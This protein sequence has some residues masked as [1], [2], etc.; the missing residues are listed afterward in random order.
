MLKILGFVERNGR[1]TH[2]EYR[3]GHV[4]FH[5]SFGRRLPNIRGY[6]LNIRAGRPIGETLGPLA[7]RLTHGEPEGFDEMWDGWGQLMFD[8]HADYLAARSPARDRAG[9][10]GLEMD[11]DVAGIG[12]DLGELF[13]GSPFQLH[14]EEHVAIPVRRPERKLFKLVQFVK[15]RN[16]LSPEEF[17]AYW[18]GRTCALMARM[19]GL[20][21]LI[22]NIRTAL[23]V[24]TGFYAPESEAFTEAGIARREAFFDT[25]DGFAE[26]WFDAPEQ[27]TAGRND[28][29]LGPKL[30]AL[31]D[32]LFGTVFYR[33]VDET[34][35]VNA[36]RA[37][38]PDFYFR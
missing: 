33:E 23:N 30:D 4:G 7:A 21:G 10:N 1:L 17:R 37:P 15:R 9:P 16:D 14:A 12:G 29:A 27:F 31:E 2:D 3:A 35:A 32:E 38:A 26:F 8:T 24:S 19:P 36:N 22:V 13:E 18:T 11:K 20:R 34:I 6:A 28:P 25:W 5:A